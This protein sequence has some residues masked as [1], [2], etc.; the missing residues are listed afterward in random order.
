MSNADV[1]NAPSP[2]SINL[3]NHFIPI[4]FTRYHR[5][6]LFAFFFLFFKL[7]FSFF[8]FG[9][10]RKTHFN[11]G[12]VSFNSCTRYLILPFLSKHLFSIKIDRRDVS[13]RQPV[14][15]WTA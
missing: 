4:L 5:E 11:R 13:S 3:N 15:F 2:D 7:G 1:I 10:N 8:R 6:L 9:D 14:L 12:E